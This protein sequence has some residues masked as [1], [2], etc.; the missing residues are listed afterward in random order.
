MKH[1]VFPDLKLH[2]IVGEVLRIVMIQKFDVSPILTKFG[3]NKIIF[4]YYF[5]LVSGH[6]IMSP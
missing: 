3:Q 4:L 6:I 5:R 2:R 1:K